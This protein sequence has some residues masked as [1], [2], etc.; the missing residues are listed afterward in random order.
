MKR[1][2]LRLQTFDVD[3]E[4]PLVVTFQSNNQLIITWKC[5]KLIFLIYNPE[6]NY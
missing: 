2:S 5:H 1:N 6:I 3:S 4:I